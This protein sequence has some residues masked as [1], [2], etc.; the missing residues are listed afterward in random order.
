MD[1][2]KFI[3]WNFEF[4]SV[5][6][7]FSEIV[8]LCLYWMMQDYVHIDQ[9]AA[10]AAEQGDAAE[11]D[12]EEQML[13]EKMKLL[14]SRLEGNEELS[15]REREILRLILQ[16]KKRKEIAD[17]LHLS[18]NTIKTHTRTLYSKL[19][20]ASREEIRALVETNSDS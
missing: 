6:Y 19:S 2:R 16:N 10:V 9:V 17:E 20:V 7:I 5:T 8:L 14:A 18:E 11:T 15:Q 13:E 3:S 12:T 1:R 4:L